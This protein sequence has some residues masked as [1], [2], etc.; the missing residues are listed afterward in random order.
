MAKKCKQEFITVRG[1]KLY[2]EFPPP[3]RDA[4]GN[5]VNCVGMMSFYDVVHPPKERFEKEPPEKEFK[6]VVI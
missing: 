3:P 4:E 6:G 5:A 1:V 2:G